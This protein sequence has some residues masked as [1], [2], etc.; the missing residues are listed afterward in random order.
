VALALKDLTGRDPKAVEA[1][2]MDV[3]NKKYTKFGRARCGARAPVIPAI[4][5]GE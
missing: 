3:L 4:K 2:F 1:K 5:G